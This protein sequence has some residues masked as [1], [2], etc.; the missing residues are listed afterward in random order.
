MI[1]A[2]DSGNSKVAFGFFE[3]EKLVHVFTAESRQGAAADEYTA[4]LHTMITRNS[5]QPWAIE[6]IVM[7]SVVT[8][9]LP[10]L[11]NALKS[12]CDKPPLLVSSRVRLNIAIKY[13]TPETLGSDRIAAACAAYETHGGPVIV[14]DF[15]T[16]TTFSVVD[17]S[18][19]LIGGMICPGLITGYEA[20]YSRTNGI[21][22]AGLTYPRNT[23]GTN[24]AEGV[25]SGIIL[26][27]AAMAD[28]IIGMIRKEVGDAPVI[29][30][31]GLSGMVLPHMETKAVDEQYLTLKGLK[32]IQRLNL[33]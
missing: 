23:I 18:G 27:H 12:I 24:T 11:F 21:P 13:K 30:T 7:S 17:G 22:K 1:L 28:G 3:G 15:G 4:F 2:V 16:A 9:M 20:L 6:S 19:G 26:G 14:A 31:G 32:L 10:V 8:P 29:A 25:Q 33:K 5:I